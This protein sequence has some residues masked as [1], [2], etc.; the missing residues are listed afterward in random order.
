MKTISKRFLKGGLAVLLC[1]I[2]LFSSTIT[3]FAAVV[4]NAQT[5]AN[6]NVA[7]TSANTVN[8]GYL[9]FDNTV[10]GWTDKYI[11]FCIGHSSYTS[12]YT[13][14]KLSGTN[15]YYCKMDSWSGSTYYAV[16]GNDS[17]WS[18]G[19]WGT[20]NLSNADHYTAAYTSTYGLNSDR[21]YV[22]SPASSSNGC[23]LS[24]SYKGSAASSVNTT[25]YAYA[26]SSEY[27]ASSYSTNSSAGTVS[28]SSK[29]L[30]AY[31]TVSTRSVSSS[32]GSTYTAS[33][34]VALSASTTL[35]A[36]AADGYNFKGWSTSTSE[37]GIVSTSTTY[38]YTAG[39]SGYTKYY[40]LFEEEPT[41]TVTFNANGGTGA[42]SA[43]T[44]IASGG[45]ATIPDTT[46]TLDGY[47][48]SSW[49]TKSDGSG[50]AYF[51]GGTISNITSDI[52]LYAQYTASDVTYSFKDWDGT[53]LKEETIKSGETPVAPDNPT[54]EGYTFTGWTP[55]VS[56][57]TSDTVYTATYTIKTY[58]VT[59]VDYDGTTLDT[60]TVDHGSTATA[61]ADPTRTGYTFNGWTI[62][63]T[64]VDLSVYTINTDTTLTA[65]YTAN[66]YTVGIKAYYTD[67]GSTCTIVSGNTGFATTGAGTYYYG[68]E[69]TLTATAAD[70]YRFLGW[71]SSS[72]LNSTCY[73]TDSSYTFTFEPTTPSSYYYPIFIKQYVVSIVIPEGIYS[74][75]FNGTNYT[76]D[77]TV[78]VDAGTS[79]T[80][81]ATAKSG[82]E[83]TGWESGED[84]GSVTSDLTFTP[85]VAKLYTLT[86]D[87]TVKG[88]YK[89]GET[90]T[91]TLTAPSGQYVKSVTAV[92]GN[93][94]AVAVS[95]SDGTYTL[96]MPA[97]NVTVSVTY[98][99]KN[100][101]T[102]SDTTGLT[103]TGNAS[104]Y[105]P[106]E[107]VSITVKPSSTQVT[108]NSLTSSND[109]LTVTKNGGTYTITGTMPDEEVTITVDVEANF[110]V[111]YGEVAIGNYGTGVTSDFGTV[112]ITVDDTQY[113]SGS[114]VAPN[115]EVTYT[116]TESNSNY[117]FVGFYSNEA[118]TKLL[119]YNDTYTVTPTADTTV[120][121]LFARRQYMTYD[122]E[123]TGSSYV[124]ELVYDPSIGAY[125]HT[126]TL[127]SSS[128]TSAISTSAWFLVTNN[129]SNWSAYVNPSAFT[130]NFNANGYA[131]TISDNGSAWVLSTEAS[132]GDNIKFIL[133]PTSSSEFDF[134][135]TTVKEGATIYLSSGWLS[136]PGSYSSTSAFTSEVTV[137]DSGTLNHNVSGTE[138]DTEAYVTAS[139]TTAQI[140]TFNTT[141]SGDDAANYYVD[142]YVVYDILD[143]TYTIITPNTLSG[144]VYQGSVYVDSDCYIVPV[145][146]HTEAYLEENS[147]ETI[148]V[149]FDA[150]AVQ[151][152]SWGPFVAAYSWGSKSAEYSGVWPGQIMI[153]TEDGS[154]WYTQIE[155]PD[156]TA[157][158]PSSVPQGV[159]FMNY[160]YGDD[161]IPSKFA[162]AFGVTVNA[163]QSYDYREP[164]T[165]YE[166]EYDVITFVAK[167]SQDGYH[168][169]SADS[170]NTATA[171]PVA[172]VT[173]ALN[174]NFVFDYLYTRDGV[175]P[176]SFTG[177][178]IE[179]V[180]K[181]YDS[182]GSVNNADFY[183]ISEGDVDIAAGGYSLDSNYHG[184]WSVR[185]HIFNS[186]GTKLATV[187]SDQMYQEASSDDYAT[188]LLQ[189]IGVKDASSKIVAISYEAPNNDSSHSH[190]TSY[191][192]QWYG[193]KLDDTI[194]GNVIVGLLD[195]DGNYNIDEE[196]PTNIADYGAGYLVDE[197]G[198]KFAELDISMDY[199][200]ADLSATINDG[201]RFIGWHTKNANGSYV[202]ISD[203]INYSTY[204]NM[205]TT[206]YAIFKEIAE[207]ELVVNHIKYDNQND[208]YIPSHSGTASLTI[209]VA[210]EDGNVYTGTPSTTISTVA[211]PATE[212][213]TYTITITTTPLLNGEFFAWYTDSTDVSGNK[214]YEEIGTEEDIVGSTEMVSFTYEYTYDTELNIIN[215]YS[216][217]TRVSN[218]ADIF[219]KY[220]NRFGEYRT[221][222]VR[223]IELTDEECEGYEGNYFNEYCPT[224]LT[225]YTLED[226]TVV[227]GE[228]ELEES[229]QEAVSSYNVVQMYAPSG[230]VTEA[231]NY[232]NSWD[233]TD[234]TITAGKSMITVVAYQD[235][236][237]YT[238]T[239][240]MNGHTASVTEEYNDNISLVAEAKNSAGEPFSYWY[241]PATGEIL[242][243]SRYY[244]YRVVEDKTIE[245]VY[246]ATITDEWT[247][248]INSVTY[249]REYSDTSDYIYTDYLLA[250]NNVDGKELDVVKTEE[251]I[252]YGFILVRDASYFIDS[253]VDVDQNGLLDD[254]VDVTYVAATDVTDNLKTVA[255]GGKS[256]AIDGYNYYCYDLTNQDTTNKNRI[257]YYLKYNNNYTS[258]KGYKYRHYAFTAVAYIV[259]DGT[260]YLSN[261]E[262]VNFYELANSAVT[263]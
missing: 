2:M 21:Y 224:Y 214:T 147:M 212:G 177:E 38:T 89:A 53:T 97:S 227:Y 171:N 57:I 204:I 219:Y 50:T 221:Y 163:L 225:K 85:A 41:Y 247:P 92:D 233:V 87:G 260:V 153:P 244:Y 12:L 222:T 91:F 199:G 3:G 151:G 166:A 197:A 27:G 143:K 129:Q 82:Y 36:T 137:G 155:V 113:S 30:S 109:S 81:Y 220:L 43:I 128:S 8:G 192:G 18:S 22:F 254:N 33:G 16:I 149:Y 234:T 182:K 251:N 93:G 63:G 191:D 64:A 144:N 230:D 154:S 75:T 123:Q 170:T 67:D 35:T 125:T 48:F 184:S 146:F 25:N 39:H 157:E 6:V 1:V 133:T 94:D 72:N 174:G 37:S 183:V 188:S 31:N 215:L 58:T 262:Y 9:Y 74:V 107:A 141:L 257:N 210:D 178:A 235:V 77:T 156:S 250:Y 40:A 116:A 71:Y 13:M 169:D 34:T 196:D 46:P 142:S 99:D 180:T 103:I 126:A 10:T 211:F 140:I 62:A 66:S 134:S 104:P 19:S 5:S 70:G 172:G 60:Q 165:L 207:G 15:L 168:G 239:Y 201:Y 28:L 69:V 118:C 112:T 124:K 131:A 159:Q 252:S 73:T 7:D 209:E 111:A 218:K 49:N 185:W 255:T 236:Q 229:G 80:A 44:D 86:V 79:Y 200:V 190:Q 148:D 232:I 186:D 205:N 193:N 32:L 208:P 203:A 152:T 100:N 119:T 101:I 238:I 61:P 195:T 179:G 51:V 132:S 90:A 158:N 253:K 120:Y 167:T 237:C 56:A 226:G 261:P 175:T 55:T 136:L 52:T 11:Y 98:A 130:R 241:E 242:T 4:D 161:T 162:S 259:V 216:D 24:I 14:T 45:S 228:S 106:G 68:D 248:S 20:S 59:F 187:L 213:K 108:I 160:L 26:Y 96:T 127:G 78:S 189:A 84:S 102:F 206:Y 47:I 176:M 173:N 145:L 17:S 138:H 243:Y 164:I 135:A 115:T 256:Q 217:V 88:S 76:A 150:T 231:F 194:Y 246:G 223:D 110:A 105:A 29:Y 198:D 95:A 249:T 202:L 121:A 240:T 122:R 65:S 117:T 23:S 42:P 114:Y 181:S 258:S 263:N 83:V 54:R 245:A 139:I